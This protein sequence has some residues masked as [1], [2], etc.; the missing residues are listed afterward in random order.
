MKSCFPSD[1]FSLGFYRANNADLE[2]F[3]DEELLKHYFEHGKKENRVSTE[4]SSKRGFLSL[5]SGQ[6]A[7]LEIGV[8]DCPTLDFIA[9]SEESIVVHYADFLSRKELI[10]RA[11]QVGRNPKN[12]PEIKWILSDGYEQ[13]DVIYDAVVSHHC[14]EHQPDLI[15]HLLNII[16]ILRPGGWYLF[17]VPHKYRCFDFF[18]PESTIVDVIAAHYLEY[19]KPSFKSILEHRVFTSHTY[20]DGVNPYDSLQSSVKKLIQLAFDEFTSNEYVDVHCWQFTPDSIRK[21]LK[22]LAAFE[23]IPSI[24][25]LK[26]YPNLDELYVAISFS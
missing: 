17:S 3:S 10:A 24:N 12:V 16:S 7:L 4:I 19:T 21:L 18:I 25:E 8:F 20:Q 1:Q 14:V 22:Q 11:D 26:V 9:E 6:K 15:A 2:G 13:I 5:L 23:L